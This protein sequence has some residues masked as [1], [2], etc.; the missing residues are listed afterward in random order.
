[1]G[2]NVPEN[3]KEEVAKS[4]KNSAIHSSLPKQPTISIFETAGWHRVLMK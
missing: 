2:T 1:M 4:Y 3:I